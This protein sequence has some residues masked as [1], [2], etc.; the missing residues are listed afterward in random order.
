MSVQVLYCQFYN[1]ET[2]A[3]GQNWKWLQYL[4]DAKFFLYS[5]SVSNANIVLYMEKNVH[6][7]YS[8]E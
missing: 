2:Q 5:I 6:I 7:L 1:T 8:T 3:E 4:Q